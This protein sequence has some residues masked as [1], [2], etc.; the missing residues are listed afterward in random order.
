MNRTANT[1]RIKLI[2]AMSVF[3]TIGIFRRYIPLP[4]RMIALV[5]GIVGTAF[6]LLVI[7]VQKKPLDKKVIRENF[8]LLFL[9][10]AAIGVNWILLFEAYCYTSVATATLCYYLAPVLMILGAPIVLKDKLT[11]RQ[12]LCAAAALCGMVPVSGILETGISDI[13]EMKGILYGIGAAILYASV[14]LMNKKLP[15]I[16]AYDKTI[17]QLFFASVTL[18]PYVLL[19]EHISPADYT[20]ISLLLLIAV[21]IV[22]TGLAYWMYFGSI[23]N[24]KA[25]TVALWSY[26]DPVLAIILST[27]L[28]REPM[29]IPAWIG[30]AVILG[31]AYLCEQ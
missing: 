24:L 16:N 8:L 1:D 7:L 20:P 12:G 2:S 27:L 11:L 14:I 17:V 26:L 31:A 23:E 25:Q 30:A 19:T 9:S 22:H 3:G 5:R 4:S 6:L 15:K 21:G 29:G 10:G 28:L 13:S 18:L